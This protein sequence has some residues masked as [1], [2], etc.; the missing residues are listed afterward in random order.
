MMEKVNQITLSGFTSGVSNLSDAYTVLTIGKINK[1]IGTPPAFEVFNPTS[2]DI[3]TVSADL[4]EPVARGF[5]AIRFA[6]AR[7]TE[8][9]T[10]VK[11]YVDN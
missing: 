11:E 5:S 4:S 1:T 8:V 10:E 9:Q 3:W 2:N 6:S 7:Y